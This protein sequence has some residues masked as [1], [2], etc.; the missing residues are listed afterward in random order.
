MS[1][2]EWDEAKKSIAIAVRSSPTPRFLYQ[3]AVVRVKDHDLAGARKSLDTAF[4]EG[5]DMAT[6]NL[7]GEVM[8]QQKEFPKYVALVKDAA[9]KNPGSVPLQNALGRQ[10]AMAGDREGARAAFEI[11]LRDGDVVNASCEIAIIDL[12]AGKPD[13]ARQRL[14]DL[15]KT[16]DNARARMMLAELEASKGS[17]DVVIQHYLKAI[18]LEPQNGAAMNNLAEFLA[19]QKKFDDALFWAQE[20]TGAGPKQ[21]H[22]GRYHRLDLLPRG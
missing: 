10:L 2:G 3:D 13:A 1:A 6:L 19:E 18:A 4:Q 9:A 5:P 17:P 22:R 8:Q 7:L 16:H 11:A 15:V 14:L 20:G 21:P 12:A